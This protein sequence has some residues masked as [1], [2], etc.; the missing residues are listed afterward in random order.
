MTKPIVLSAIQPNHPI[1]LGNYLGA[2]RNWVDFQNENN[3]Y[4]FVVDL[5]AITGK[6]DP[7]SIHKNSLESLA[8]Y[9]AA[10]IDPL[11]STLFIQSHVP[12][13]AELAWVLNS[14]SNMG[15]L[16]RM[17][18]FKNKSE[19][20]GKNIKVGLYTYPIL[21]ASDIL[22][23]DTEKVPVGA[24]QKQHVELTRN[25]AIRMNNHFNEEVFKVPDPYIPKAGAKI[26][27]LQE[28]TKKMS[29]SDQNDK[30]T[31]F[32][33]EPFKSIEKKFKKAVTDS[34]TEI[35]YDENKPG[36]KNLLEIQR[37]I[38][39][40][41][42]EELVKSYEGKMYGHLK[43]ETAELVIET[44]RP[45]QEK[46]NQILENKTELEK[47]LKDGAEKAKEHAQKTLKRVY[48]KLGFV[49]G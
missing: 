17:T 21:M 11:K 22:L 13:H 30:A 40:K 27:S 12:Q 8:Y 9:I 31:V 25:I 24:D 47:T 43:V 38:T 34:G 42:I 33:N 19:K 26:M 29:K 18:Q 14:F 35:T 6:F 32:I 4:F 3:C 44:L 28:P 16:N 49:R 5:H 15:E 45:I 1:T 20:A 7:K 36:V 23:Y 41:P 10:G 46:A 48:E 37:S 39:Q 2:L